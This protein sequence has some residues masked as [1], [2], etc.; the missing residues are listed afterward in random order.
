[1]IKELKAYILVGIGFALLTYWYFWLATIA[2]LNYVL[3]YVI[4]MFKLNFNGQVVPLESLSRGDYQSV[5]MFG[6]DY[7]AI[8]PEVVR[9]FEERQHLL[10]YVFLAELVLFVIIYFSTGGRKEAK[11]TRPDDLIQVHSLFQRMVLL[12]NILVVIYLVIT[13]FSITF[14]NI[15]GGGHLAYLMRQ[16]HEIV[17]LFW[18][19][20]WLLV[21]IIAFK[22]H[23]YFMRPSVKWSKFFLKGLYTHSQRINY[24]AFVIFGFILGFSGFWIWFLQP[25]FASHAQVIQFK[26]IIL[27]GHFM[28]SAVITFFIA[29]T[30]YTYVVSVKGYLPGLITGKYPKEY[31]EKFHPEILEEEITK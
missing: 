15:T 29:E 23:K 12:G 30:I 27:F 22:D 28:G 7:D 14:G 11:I 24:F 3:A 5:M 6:P 4:E 20:I 16:T 10:P 9:A 31:L 8:A 2:D 1:M 18:I 13:G 21:T 17:G 19:P 26:R 25:D